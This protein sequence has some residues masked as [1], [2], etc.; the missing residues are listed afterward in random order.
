MKMAAATETETY[1]TCEEGFEPLLDEEQLW[2]LL[3]NA[4]ANEE[5]MCAGILEGMDTDELGLSD[6]HAYSILG[7]SDSFDDYLHDHV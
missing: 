7:V 2:R 6:Q 3:T 5:L 1:F 4:Y